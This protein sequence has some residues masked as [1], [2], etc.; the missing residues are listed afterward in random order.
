MRLELL[1]FDWDGTLMD[2]EERIVDCVR[3]AI[4]EVGAEPRDEDSIRNI[5][6][7]GLRE[8]VL[9]LYPQAE[10]RFVEA[11]SGA[12]RAHFLSDSVAPSVPFP[13]ARTVLEGL[14]AQGYRLAVATGK[15]RTGLDKALAATGLGAWFHASR[16]ADEARS[17]P[18]PQ[19]LNELMEAL[20]VPPE[21]TLMIG[22]T[23]YDLEMARNA[24]ARGLAVSYGVHSLE[25]L[26]GERPAGHIDALGELPAWL[27]GHIRTAP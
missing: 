20:E 3:R 4:E 14:F 27:E 19:M 6:G 21:R 18:H 15:G 26:L 7:L 23:V 5:I 16:C 24:G 17:K 2:S 12:Y 11:L 22:D 1:V 13:G 8:A 25:R 10:E 9:T